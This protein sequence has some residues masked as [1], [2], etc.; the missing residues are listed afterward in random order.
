M[1]HP[2]K[3]L[4]T[5]AVGAVSATLIAGSALGLA[6]AAQAAPAAVR[7]VDITGDGGTVLKAN[8]VTPADADGTRA[9]PAARAAHELGPA[10]G[11]VPRPGPETRELRLCRGQLQ[12]PR[13]LAVGRRDRSGGPTRHSRRL[14]G[15][16]LGARQHPGRRAAHRHGGRLVRRRHQPARRRARQARQGRRRPSAAGPTSSTRSTPAAPS[17]SRPPPCWTARAWSP[18]ARAPNSSRSST[19]S[20]PPTSTRSRS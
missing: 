1:G 6:P 17:T 12:R 20:T 15:H 19:T 16:R 8:V 3:A 9:L 5:T 14:Q 7:F 13:L 18:A 2:R 11:R 10:P 4:R